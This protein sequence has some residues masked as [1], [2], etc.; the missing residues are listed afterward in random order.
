MDDAN[1]QEDAKNDS[2]IN[3]TDSSIKGSEKKIEPAQ[4]EVGPNLF[5]IH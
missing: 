4:A 2:V 1:M 3:Q 5:K